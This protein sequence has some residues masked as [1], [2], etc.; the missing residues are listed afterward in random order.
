MV[1]EF[2]GPFDSGTWDRNP[3]QERNLLNVED[4]AERWDQGPEEGHEHQ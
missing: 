4:D 1:F 2:K 3:P